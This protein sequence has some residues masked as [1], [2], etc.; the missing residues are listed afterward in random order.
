MLTL[1]IAE[2]YAEGK[3]KFKYFTICGVYLTFVVTCLQLAVSLAQIKD[4]EEF[5]AR[6][7]KEVNNA[8]IGTDDS[9]TS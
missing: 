6:K 7:I 8:I 2:F 5:R 3:P 4:L 9:K 1:L